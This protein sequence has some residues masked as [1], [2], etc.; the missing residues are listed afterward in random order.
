MSKRENGYKPKKTPPMPREAAPP[1]L[2][3]ELIAQ[4]QN[5]VSAAQRKRMSDRNDSAAGSPG[6][7]I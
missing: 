4:L 3:D 2:S 6:K 5:A 7:K 1:L